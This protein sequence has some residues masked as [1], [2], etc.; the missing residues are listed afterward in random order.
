MHN[1]IVSIYLAFV[2]QHLRLRYIRTAQKWVGQIS[3]ISKLGF[4]IVRLTKMREYYNCLH[5]QRAAHDGIWMMP[6]GF[7]NSFTSFAAWF[8]QLHTQVAP[9]KLQP[10]MQ[11]TQPSFNKKLQTQ[12]VLT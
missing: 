10:Q 6:Q 4:H 11:Q 5:L 7:E 8:E 12:N 3:K 1:R 9:A 2:V